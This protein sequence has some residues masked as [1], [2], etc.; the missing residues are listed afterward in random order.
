LSV[1]VHIFDFSQVIYGKEIEVEFIARIR[2]EIEFKSKEELVIQ[3][4]NDI[5][6]AKIFLEESN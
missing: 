5:K 3:I 4:N 1:E 2:S 6:K